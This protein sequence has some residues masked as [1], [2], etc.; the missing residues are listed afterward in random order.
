MEKQQKKTPNHPIWL[1]V[2]KITEA[3]IKAFEN[4][5]N[6][7]IVIGGKK[8]N[9]KGKSFGKWI[10]NTG[11]HSSL[12]NIPLAQGSNKLQQSIVMLAQFYLTKNENRD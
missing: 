8:Q 3:V 5:L 1:L 12:Q 9:G 10:S 2:L 6:I 4:F 7:Q 11:I